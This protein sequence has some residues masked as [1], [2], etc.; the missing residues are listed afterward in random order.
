MRSSLRQEIGNYIK[1]KLKISIDKVFQQI[2]HGG[3]GMINVKQY[4]EGLGVSL[5]RRTLTSN[6]FWAYEIKQHLINTDFAFHFK[7][8]INICTIKAF[9]NTFIN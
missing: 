6:D 9:I 4:I 7:S 3:L 2:S 1:Y 8:N 5:Y